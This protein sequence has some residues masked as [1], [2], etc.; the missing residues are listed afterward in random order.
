MLDQWFLRSGIRPK[1]VGEFED[2]ALLKVFAGEGWGLFAAPTVIERETERHY[3]LRTVGRI[4][5]V[6]ERYYAISLERKLKHPSVLAIVEAAQT[7][8]FG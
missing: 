7:E 1:V 5:D 8:T 3:G 2:S 6:R 4:E